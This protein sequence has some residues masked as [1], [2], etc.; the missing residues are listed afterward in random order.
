MS[1]DISEHSFEEAIECALLA[2]GP[3]A[4]RADD[5]RVSET[6]PPDGELPP[7]GYHRRDPKEYDRKRCLLPR[8]VLDFIY[9]TF[10]ISLCDLSHFCIPR[11]GPLHIS[12]P[13]EETVMPNQPTYHSQVLD[14]LGLVAGMFDELGIGDVIDQ[15]TRHKPGNARPHRGGSRQSDGAQWLGVYQSSALPRPQILPS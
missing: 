1:P 2:H 12:S 15:A 4:F 10:R 13:S 7:G 11:G 14:H 3:D 9:P 8:E 6:P 5:P